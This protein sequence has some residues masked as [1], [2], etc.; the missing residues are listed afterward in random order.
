MTVKIGKCFHTGNMAFPRP[1]RT[2]EMSICL[3]WRENLR[4]LDLVLVPSEDEERALRVGRIRHSL[5][6]FKAVRGLRPAEQAC[7]K[8]KTTET[9]AGRKTNNLFPWNQAGF[10]LAELPVAPDCSLSSFSQ[11]FLK[12]L[13]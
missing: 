3:D 13:S 11:K 4:T 2:Q 7:Q 5:G 6:I 12:R 1:G 10:F 9:W 8:F